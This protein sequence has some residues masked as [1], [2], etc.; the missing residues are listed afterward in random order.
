MDVRPSHLRLHPELNGQEI[1]PL[2]A[3][4]RRKDSADQEEEEAGSGK[5]GRLRHSG[6]GRVE[7][8]K[9]NLTKWFSRLSPTTILK[10]FLKQS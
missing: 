7:V 6:S 9:P 1:V 4:G 3:S 8:T 2:R 5:D 10:C